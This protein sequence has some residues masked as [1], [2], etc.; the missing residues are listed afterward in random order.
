MSTEN[1][2]IG[3]IALA[4]F[5]ALNAQDLEAFIAL[6]HEEVEFTSMVAEAEGTTFRGHAGVRAWW[7]T[8]AGAFEHVSWEVVELRPATDRGVVKVRL[9]GTLAGVEVSQLMW[10]AGRIRDGKLVWWAFFRTEQEALEAV[11]LSERGLG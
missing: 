1:A 3:A 11:G 6:T 4:A 10:Q 5:E 8:V 2:E 9:A 7:D